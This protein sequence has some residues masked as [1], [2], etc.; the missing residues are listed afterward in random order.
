MAREEISMAEG[1]MIADRVLPRAAVPVS[2]SKANLLHSIFSL[3]W[4]EPSRE[5]CLENDLN[6]SASKASS[7]DMHSMT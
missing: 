4:Q 2:V 3:C 7:R 5:D 6:R 1:E